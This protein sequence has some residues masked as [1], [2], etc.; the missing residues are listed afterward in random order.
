[1]I[2]QAL[3]HPSRVLAIDPGMSGAVALVGAGRI[4]VSRD[5][6]SLAQIVQ[7]IAHLTQDRPAEHVI[8]EHVHAMPGQGVS[9]MFN[10]GKATGTAYGASLALMNASR[11]ADLPE[12]VSPLKWQNWYR[13]Q[14]N[15][16][17]PAIFDSRAIVLQLLPNCAHLLKR[18]KDHNTADAILLALWKL[19]HL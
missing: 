5:F 1:M 10:F 9:S 8:I 2:A 12:E 18:K 3:N 11:S 14:L 17:R 13:Q 4:H 15:I 16:L 19:N 6:K 7:A